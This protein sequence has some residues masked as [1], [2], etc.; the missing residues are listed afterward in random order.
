MRHYTNSAGAQGIM[1]DG[2]IKASDQNKVFLLRAKGR[3]LSPRDAERKLGIRRGHGQKVV[4]FDAPADRI[5][6]RHNPVM[7]I[8]EWYA[9]GNLAVTNIKV[10]R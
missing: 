5:F 9:E 6:S 1:R 4:E 10:V 7:G 3:L 8:T 2:V